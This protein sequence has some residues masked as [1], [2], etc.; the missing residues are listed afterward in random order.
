MYATARAW[1]KNDSQ[2]NKQAEAIDIYPPPAGEQAELP[3]PLAPTAGSR[4][5]LLIPTES[6]FPV[7]DIINSTTSIPANVLLDSHVVYM[8]EVKKWCVPVLQTPFCGLYD[9]S[10][11]G[12]KHKEHIDTND[13][14]RD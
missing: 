8:Q 11:S 3:P 6:S 12:G 1:V 14:K 5:K 10:V 4:A 13:T 7:D 9:D 2:S